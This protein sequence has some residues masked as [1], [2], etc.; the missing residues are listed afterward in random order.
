[1]RN[2][3]QIDFEKI[4]KNDGDIIKL[5]ETLDAR[6]IEKIL[7]KNKL[8]DINTNK[9]V[10]MFKDIMNNISLGMQ[11]NYDTFEKNDILL[12][13]DHVV[14]I[15]LVLNKSK[16]ANVVSIAIEMMGRFC[17][18]R[19]VAALEM[20][21]RSANEW[22]RRA[23]IGASSRYRANSVQIALGELAIN[24]PDEHVRLLAKARMAAAP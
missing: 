5:Y 17:D 18:K 23:A 11:T 15:V 8:S 13:I 21:L 24:D 16:M 6:Y 3:E 9:V 10:S 4:C 7:E 12:S 20:H 1:M 2:I 22:E 14:Y 19:F